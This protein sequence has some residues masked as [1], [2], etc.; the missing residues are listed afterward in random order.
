MPAREQAEQLE[1]AERKQHLT[2]VAIG[3]D[4]EVRAV[5]AF[6]DPLEHLCQSRVEVSNVRLGRWPLACRPRMQQLE[7]VL[8]APHDRG[9]FGEQCVGPA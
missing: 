8:G 5:A 1:L 4:Q 6:S 2:G 7:S 9:A 3:I